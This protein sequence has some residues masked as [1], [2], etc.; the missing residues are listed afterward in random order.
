MCT[1]S[2]SVDMAIR[3]HTFASVFLALEAHTFFAAPTLASLLLHMSEANIKEASVG[4]YLQKEGA[5]T[6]QDSL[7]NCFDRRCSFA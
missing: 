2:F 5:P 1:A 6:L 3:H 4:R 7:P